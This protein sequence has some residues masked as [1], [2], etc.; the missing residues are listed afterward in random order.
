MAETKTRQEAANENVQVLE[1]DV[2]KEKENVARS[3][4]ELV[5]EN[6]GN[7]E[8]HGDLMTTRKDLKPPQAATQ[9]VSKSVYSIQ[10]SVSNM[11]HPMDDTVRIEAETVLLRVDR[12]HNP[13]EPTARSGPGGMPSSVSNVVST[14][15]PLPHVDYPPGQA[16]ML[17]NPNTKPTVQVKERLHAVQRYVQHLCFGLP[18]YTR[19]AGIVDV[20]I[21]A[22]LCAAWLH[23]PRR[24][25]H[26]F[27]ANWRA[28]STN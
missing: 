9:E 13:S 22:F 15:P 20:V 17:R 5:N 27:V 18:G 6:A 19:T 21:I 1:A 28:W 2:T 10:G 3:G 23:C 24:S 7:A 4:T 26:V 12:I 14:T 16:G 25:W 8:L 11:T